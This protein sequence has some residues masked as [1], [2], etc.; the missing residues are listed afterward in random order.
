MPRS[1]PPGLRKL[2]A[3]RFLKLRTQLGLTQRELAKEFKSA[4]GAIAQWETGVS[5]IPG[6]VLRLLEIYESGLI[7]PTLS[8]RAQPRPRRSNLER[9]RVSPSDKLRQKSYKAH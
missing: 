7:Q 6:S 8:K 5:T 2:E 9:D 3:L 1:T 4:P